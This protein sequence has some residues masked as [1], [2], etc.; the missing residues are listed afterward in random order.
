MS[1]ADRRLRI[2]CISAIAE[3]TFDWHPAHADV[4]TLLT[5]MGKVAAALSLTQRMLTDPVPDLVLNV[6]TAGTL[7]HAVGDILVCDHFFDCDLQGGG[8]LG[9]I[10]E[11][12]TAGQYPWPFVSQKNGKPCAETFAVN[13]G[14]SFVT[15]VET[16]LPGDTIDMEAFAAAMVCQHFGVPFLAVKYITDVVGQNSV[17]EWRD[18]LAQARTAL[19]RYFAAYDF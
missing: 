14:D 19:Q 9:L 11:H 17:G 1:N 16:P 8:A 12:S 7:Q 13:T 4:D 10:Y 5:G 15:T 2:L 3:E 18:R 6:G